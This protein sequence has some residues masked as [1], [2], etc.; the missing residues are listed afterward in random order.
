MNREFGFGFGFQAAWQRSLV[1]ISAH[2]RSIFTSPASFSSGTF[3]WRSQHP[4]DL[5][6]ISS[7]WV[8]VDNRYSFLEWTVPGEETKSLDCLDFIP[9]DNPWIS[10]QVSSVPPSL[11]LASKALPDR[12]FIRRISLAMWSHS[13]STSPGTLSISLENPKRYSNGSKHT[14][15]WTFA[16]IGNRLQPSGAQNRRSTTS[17]MKYLDLSKVNPHCFSHSGRS[18]SNNRPLS[19]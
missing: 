10:Y 16:S 9:L 5:I 6:L 17:L 8:C 13:A 18:S 3:H 2:Q 14:F 11:L 7:P 15:Q 19:R 4:Q 12:G 1:Y